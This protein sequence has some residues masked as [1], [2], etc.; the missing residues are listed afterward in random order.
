M[1]LMP[2]LCSSSLC[3]AA[4]TH[5]W[6]SPLRPKKCSYHRWILTRGLPCPRLIARM[7]QDEKITDQH[8]VLQ[9]THTRHPHTT[10]HDTHDTHTTHL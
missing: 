2:Q 3:M 9:R 4:D 1:Y 8:A 5:R 10:A 7:L 6:A